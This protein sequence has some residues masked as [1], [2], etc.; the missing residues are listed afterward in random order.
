[1]CCKIYH[2]GRDESVYKAYARE[3]NEWV[4]R[5]VR[6]LRKK[7]EGR[8]EMVPAF[9]DEQRGFGLE[10]SQEE[11]HKVNAFRARQNPSRPPLKASPGLR[12]LQ[13]GKQKQ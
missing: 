10:L 2:V 1:M 7:T 9:Q 13:Y 5:G 6:G 11:L 3:A 4:V 8:G 12:F